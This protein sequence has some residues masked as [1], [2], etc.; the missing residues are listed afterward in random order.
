M[1]FFHHQ[2]IRNYTA[3]LLDTFN[4]VQIAR[5][6]KNG[7]EIYTPIPITFGSKDKAFI[8]T[9]I[10]QQKFLDGNFN[11]LPRMSLSLISMEADQKRNTNRLHTINKKIDGNI[12]NFH[13]NAVAY[14]LNYELDIAC[15]SLTE[16]SMAL[17]QILPY[18]NPTLNLA[19]KELAIQDE[20]TSVRVALNGT[21]LDLPDSFNMDDALRIV[22][23]KLSL[24]LNGNLYMPFKDAEMIKNV[25]LYLNHQQ[26]NELLGQTTRKEKLEFEVDQ[27][28][29]TMKDKTLY[30]LDFEDSA[31]K[32]RPN[33]YYALN[34]DGSIQRDKYNVPMLIDDGLFISGVDEILIETDSEFK[35]N[36]IDIDDE[37]DFIYVWNIISG[38]AIIGT[39]NVN[40][41]TVLFGTEPGIVVLQGQVIDKQGNVSKYVTKEIL[42]K[43]V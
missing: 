31:G 40:P 25:K 17:E 10:D 38:Q 7:K 4:S 36:F 19:I 37:K 12:I 43:E 9:T 5:T 33:Y 22:G 2:S 32:N 42:V 13:Y 30:K 14:N 21:S 15:K 16:L 6:D 35:L 8:M 39:N 20:P 26:A 24:Q 28:T 34:P 3:S 1:D 41:V 27:D 29:K 23:A 11:I 18:F